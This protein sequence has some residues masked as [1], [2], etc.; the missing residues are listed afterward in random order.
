M[1][2][3]KHYCR[4]VRKVMNRLELERKTCPPG[5]CVLDAGPFVDECVKCGALAPV[6]S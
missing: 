5:N 6:I 2:A 3:S 4:V 1:N